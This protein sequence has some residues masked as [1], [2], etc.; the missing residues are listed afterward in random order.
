[1]LPEDVSPRRRGETRPRRASRPRRSIAAS[2]CSGRR[3]SPAGGRGQAGLRPLP[4]RAL[5]PLRGGDARVSRLA[6]G[7]APGLTLAVEFRN[8]TWIPERTDEVVA[9][10]RQHGLALVTLDAGAGS[11]GW[12][13]RRRPSGPSSASTAGTS[14]AGSTS[15][16]PAASRRWPRS[17]IT[18][19]GRKSWGPGRARPASLPTRPPRGGDV[20]QQQRGLP[21]QNALDLEAAPRARSAGPRRPCARSWRP[22][23]RRAAP[24]PVATGGALGRDRQDG[25]DTSMTPTDTAG[26]RHSRPR[27]GRSGHSGPRRLVRRRPHREGPPHRGPR[28][29]AG[30]RLPLLGAADPSDGTTPPIP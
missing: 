10:L 16:A 15:S 22:G 7:A 2:S 19:T 18:S 3:W 9:F 5:G 1:M 12:R 17:T 13:R 24:S 29:A 27:R 28:G 4:A 8:E 23:R 14:A 11:R 6:A 30:R 21:T 26:H 20:Q 25:E